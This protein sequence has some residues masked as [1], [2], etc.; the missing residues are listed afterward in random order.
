MRET[1]DKLLLQY[2][3]LTGNA[4]CERLVFEKQKQAD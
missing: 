2:V 4:G 1:D 3:C